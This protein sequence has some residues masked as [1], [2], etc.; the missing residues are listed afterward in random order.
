M[1]LDFP[2]VERWNGRYGG[3]WE[4]H[5][6]LGQGQ[7]WKGGKGAL[8][9][10]LSICLDPVARGLVH[11]SK[12]RGGMVGF[13]LA[14]PFWNPF[15]LFWAFLAL[16]EA[17]EGLNGSLDIGYRRTRRW[18]DTEFLGPERKFGKGKPRMPETFLF[19][20]AWKVMSAGALF[21]TNPYKEET[22]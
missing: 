12:R 13:P 1:A 22:A 18:Y 7:S 20:K 11:R 19:R 6:P 10:S 2:R 16:K 9:K 8:L 4:I 21:P 3:E 5:F 14:I 17:E 15:C